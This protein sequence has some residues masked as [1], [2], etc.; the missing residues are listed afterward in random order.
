MFIK[1]LK[2]A[3]EINA[4]LWNCLDSAIHMK[5]EC[6]H[7]KA[8]LKH[9]H[10]V[11]LLLNAQKPKVVEQEDVKKTNIINLCNINLNENDTKVLEY[12]L[13]FSIALGIILVKEI[14]CSIENAVT[15]LP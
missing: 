8:S 2:L 15:H 14:I 11:K 7:K 3:N 1:N 4:D 5:K 13:N 6:Q 12:G 10:K 9:Q